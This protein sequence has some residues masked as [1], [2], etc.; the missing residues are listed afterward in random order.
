MLTDRMVHISTPVKI[1]EIL[2][3][4]FDLKRGSY[5]FDSRWVDTAL[6]FTKNKGGIFDIIVRMI[7]KYT[8]HSIVNAPFLLAVRMD[9]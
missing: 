2:L 7:Y 8:S 1:L 9:E 4:I 5:N 3:G 6:K